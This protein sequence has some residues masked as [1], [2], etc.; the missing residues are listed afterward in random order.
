[1][2]EVPDDFPLA[3][4]VAAFEDHRQELMDH[5]PGKFELVY[6]D[7]LAGEFDTE[8]EARA[9]GCERFGNVASGQA[10]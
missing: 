7:Q 3:R 5:A 1:L 4:E 9:A 6:G 10:D 8:D 2:V